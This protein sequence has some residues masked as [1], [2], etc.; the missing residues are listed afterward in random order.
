MREKL[1]KS[2]N[3]REESRARGGEQFDNRLSFY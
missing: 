3:V 2:D 1:Q